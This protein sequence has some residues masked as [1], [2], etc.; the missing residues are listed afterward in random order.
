MPPIPGELMALPPVPGW[1]IAG[2]VIG[3]YLIL[4]WDLVSTRLGY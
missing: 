2:A 4:L 1:L 3:V